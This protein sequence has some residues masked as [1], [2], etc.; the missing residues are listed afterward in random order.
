MSSFPLLSILVLIPLLGSLLVAL[1][2]DRL[3]RYGGFAVTGV[4]FA[5]SL[6]LAA[7][8]DAGAG[9]LRFVEHC[10]WIPGLNVDYF[11][12]VDGIGILMVLLT[13]IVTPFALLALDARTPPM[14]LYVSLILLLQATLFGTFTALNF[15]HWFVYY[16]LS[17][18]PVFLLIRMGGGKRATS[19]ALQFFIYTLFGGLAMLL[20]FLAMH[21]ATGMFNLMGVDGGRGLADLARS[22]ELAAKLAST[23]AWSGLGPNT[24]VLLIFCG[25]FLG[26]AV[27]VPVVPFHTWLPDA[28]SEAPTPVSMLMT[29]V[30]SKMGVYGFLRLLLPLFPET[31]KTVQTPL[32]ALAALTIVFSALAALAQTDLKRIVAYSSINHLG[33]C[34]LGLFAAGTVLDGA[35]DDRAAAFNGVL[36]Q[37]FNHGITAAALFCFVGF[38]ERRSNGLRGL[39]DFGGIRAVAPVLCGLMGIG[40]FSSLGLPGLNGFVGEF[41]IF[42]G[43]F[44]LAP[45]VSTISAAGLFIT[46]VFLLKMV[47]TVFTGPLNPRWLALPDLT[48]SERFVVAPIV[49]LM[50]I[51]GLYPQPLIHLFNSTVLHLFP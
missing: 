25:V 18:V 44:A 7:S 23:F 40:I 12:G 4:A 41:L 31:L 10:A 6:F 19:A 32:L 51:L 9:A 50:F 16:E 1:L 24:V 5:L 17:L 45:W 36:L 30:L 35:A 33:Y 47:Q 8:F 38:L 3:T 29:G 20:S 27:K 49:G 13:A 15:I 26:L 14:K 39:E 21:R 46:A 42:K 2:P 22:G 34:L 28:Y 37:M 43:S 11:A 48:T